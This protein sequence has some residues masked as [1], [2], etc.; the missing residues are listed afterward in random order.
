MVKRLFRRYVEAC[1]SIGV[2]P[3]ASSNQETTRQQL[4]DLAVK[5][6][7]EIATAVVI[8]EWSAL[9]SP[10]KPL[11]MYNVAEALPDLR[12]YILTLMSCS[13]SEFARLSVPSSQESKASDDAISREVEPSVSQGEATIE[14]D[15]NAIELDEEDPIA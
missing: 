13:S 6:R 8:L 11:S 10:D 1:R 7:G 2:K 4:A 12:D 5:G 14:P 15:E 3:A 9:A